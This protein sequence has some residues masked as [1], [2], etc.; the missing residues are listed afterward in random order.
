[1]TTSAPSDRPLW[2]WSACDLAGAIRDRAL[3]CEEAV[4]AVLQRVGDRNPG[5]NAIVDD[6][7]DQALETA[8][9]HD[10]LLVDHGPIGPLHGVPVTVKI[11]VD[12]EG[13]ATT[14]G[15]TAFADVIAPADSPVVRNLKNAGAIIIGRTNTPEFSFRATTQNPLHG[16]TV[17]PWDPERS[18]GGSSGGASAALAAGFGPIAHGNDIAGSLRFPAFMCGAVTVRPTLGRVPAYNPSLGAERPLLSQLMSVQG[19][20]A[21]EVRDVRVGTRVVAAADPR[22]PW[23]VPLPLEGPQIDPPIRVAVSRATNGY[24]IDPA[25]V[26]ALDRAADALDRAGYRVEE[27]TPPLLEEIAADALPAL[28]GDADLVMKEAFRSYGSETVNRI[29]D[30]YFA[31]FP[32]HQPAD[33]LKAMAERTRYARA[34]NEFAERYPLILTPFLMRPTYDWNEDERGVDAVRGIFE[35]ALYS[36]S[37]NYLGLPAAIAPAGFH[38]ELP[39]SVQLV[40]RRFRE[41]LALDAA[42]VLERANGVAIHKLWER[43]A[44]AAG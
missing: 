12:F 40:A 17:N 1:M 13:R 30:E 43:E 29:L 39:I 31:I 23:H 19:V 35:S 26:A 25:I 7:G 32:P 18:P 3:S 38:N 2:Q 37:I 15:V 9:G 16:R 8:R 11:N 42:E 6:L 22:D 27:A 33:L 5:V 41:D 20:I 34:W 21:R 28:M 44:V 36:W 10:A 4:T 14:N 24:A